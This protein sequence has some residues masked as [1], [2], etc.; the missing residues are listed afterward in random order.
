MLLGGKAEVLSA[1]DGW[2]KG[3]CRG[4]QAFPTQHGFRPRTS[5]PP[6][7]TLAGGYQQLPTYTLQ[8]PQGP[9]EAPCL[10]LYLSA[11]CVCLPVCV[12]VPVC[13]CL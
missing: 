5:A 13:V 9:P 4:K 1:S 11:V 3:A 7:C 2:Q 12:C 10:Y 6:P 8:E